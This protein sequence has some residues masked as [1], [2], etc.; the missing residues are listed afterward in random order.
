MSGRV[1]KQ[2]ILGIAGSV[3]QLA[4]VPTGNPWQPFRRK[5][6]GWHL[7]IAVEFPDTSPYESLEVAQDRY[8]KLA[9]RRP[10]VLRSTCAC[11]FAHVCARPDRLH[12]FHL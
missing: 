10:F 9:R 11:L 12:G 3:E 8:R 2:G 6:A 4:H 7:R 1:I 5:R